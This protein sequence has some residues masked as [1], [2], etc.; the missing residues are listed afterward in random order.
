MVL[1]FSSGRS[2]APP[3]RLYYLPFG[4]MIRREH[5]GARAEREAAVAEPWRLMTQAFEIEA[6]TVRSRRR[7]ARGSWSV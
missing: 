3:L 7:Q 5:E 2:G 4:E 6:E 1:H